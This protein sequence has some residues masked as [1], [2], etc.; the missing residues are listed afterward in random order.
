MR[1]IETSTEMP[2]TLFKSFFNVDFPRR[3]ECEDATPRNV[4]KPT[5]P[6]SIRV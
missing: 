5:S 4:P 3:A 1:I 6:A 2:H